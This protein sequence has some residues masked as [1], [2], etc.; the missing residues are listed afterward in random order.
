MNNIL[1][2][3]KISYDLNIIM[4]NNNYVSH[5]KKCNKIKNIF[6][7]K[8]WTIN[9]LFIN[10]NESVKDLSTKLIDKIIKISNNE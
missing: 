6:K 2:L 3:K 1:I 9:E 7:N 10:I 5:I 4:T 8:I